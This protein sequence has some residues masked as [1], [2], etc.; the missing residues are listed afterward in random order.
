LVFGLNRTTEM[1]GVCRT[2][3]VLEPAGEDARVTGASNVMIE[4]KTDVYRCQALN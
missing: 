4:I 2:G 3:T 1:V